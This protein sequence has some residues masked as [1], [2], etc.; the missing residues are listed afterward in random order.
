MTQLL[1]AQAPSFR[2]GIV[3][4]CVSGPR[5]GPSCRTALIFDVLSDGRQRSAATGGGEVR[6]RPQVVSVGADRVPLPQA[7]A[8]H[9]FQRVHQPGDGYLGRV[10]DKEMNIVDALNSL[11]I[12]GRTAQNLLGY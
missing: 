10:L 8:G 1:S 7:T 11:V 4:P 12:P 3:D 9:A 6:R 2:A 5:S